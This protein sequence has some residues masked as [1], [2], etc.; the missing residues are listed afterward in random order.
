MKNVAL[1]DSGPIIA[2]FNSKDKFHKPTL[3]FFKSYTG[4]LISTWPVVTEVVYILSFSVHAQSD[5]LEWI[6]RGSIQIIDLNLEDLK[7][8]KNRMKKYSDLPMDLADASLMCISE[9]K[10]IE[11]IISIDSDFS[12]YKNLKGK[13]LQ[14]LFKV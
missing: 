14:N 5:F 10:G 2:L 4:E 8:I 1:I 13:Y 9:K 7:Y 11:R 3:K 12:I 6:E